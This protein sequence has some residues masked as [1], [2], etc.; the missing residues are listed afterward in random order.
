VRFRPLLF[1]AALLLATASSAVPNEQNEIQELYRRGLGGDKVAVTRCIDKLEATLV[2]EPKNQ[3]ARV[4][5]GSAYTLRSRDLVFGPKKLQALRH[6]LAL[7][8]EAVA[9]EPDAP[10]IRLARALTTSSVPAFFG[11]RAQSR[12]DFEQLGQAAQIAPQ[13]FEA[14][15]LQTIKAE[16]AKMK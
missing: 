10:K 14:D 1:L 8:D 13:K 3:L 5:L 12:S 15:D 4:Y 7:M 6:G 16:L 9:A 11:R 2:A